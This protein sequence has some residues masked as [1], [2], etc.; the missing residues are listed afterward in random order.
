MNTDDQKAAGSAL[1]KLNKLI[2][3]EEMIIFTP[4]EAKAL[5]EVST[6]W[7]QVQNAVALFS[8]LG[9]SM[10]S[11]V[12]WVIFM[13]MAWTAFKAGFLDWIKEAINVK[14]SLPK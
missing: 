14:D 4:A 1:L 2:E 7:M 6:L 11:V 12:K 8:K 10:G 3:D 13:V 9:A 5:K